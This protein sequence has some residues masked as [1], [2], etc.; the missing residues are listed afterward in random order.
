MVLAAG[1]TVRYV[2]RRERAG[3]VLLYSLPLIDLLL[4][5][6]TAV[7]LAHGAEPSAGH[8]LAALYLG[9]TVA[10]GHTVIAWADARFA[11]RFAGGPPPPGPP[12]Y[13]LAR[14]RHEA[15]LWLLTLGAVAIALPV[16]EGLILVTA[17]S[18]G[19]DGGAEVLRGWQAR[20]LVALVVH[21]LIALSYAVFP[22][23]APKTADRAG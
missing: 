8:G 9:F 18:G 2:L 7:D 6:A 23:Q 13:G 10:Y 17:D 22:K 11:Y 21:G 5:T 15:R 12:K 19:A 4:L 1:L 20:A 14:A 16:L 3:R